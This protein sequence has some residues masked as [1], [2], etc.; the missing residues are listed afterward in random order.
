MNVKTKARPLT[1]REHLNNLGFLFEKAHKAGAY[2]RTV[3]VHAGVEALRALGRLISWAEEVEA[4]QAE[5]RAAQTAPAPQNP[6][7][8]PCQQ[9]KDNAP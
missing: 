2:R 1:Q 3:D 4:A 8:Q 9:A 7:C 5:I 6:D